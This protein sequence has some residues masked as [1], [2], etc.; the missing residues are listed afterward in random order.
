VDWASVF[1][2]AYPLPGAT[3]ATIAEFVAEV[4]RPLSAAEIREVH[5]KQKNP[6]PEGD[7][8][9]SAWRPFDPAAWTVP[10][11][12]IP[13]M[14]LSLLRWSN[15]GEFRSGKRWFQFF[16]ALDP[17]HGVRAMMLA[18]Q[19]PFYMP[20]ALPIALNGEGILYLFDMRGPPVGGEYSVVCA[21]AGHLGWETKACWVAAETLLEACRSSVHVDELR[22]GR[23]QSSTNA[24]SATL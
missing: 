21:H 10:G 1:D 8:L 17:V 12:P 14:Y 19:L 7:P 5:A 24:D 22:D 15:G 11:R 6:F 20:G 16:P 18:Y 4:S 3:E 9:H 2:E 13:A 23:A